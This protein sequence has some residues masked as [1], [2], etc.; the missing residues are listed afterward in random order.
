MIKDN[1]LYE[2]VTCFRTAIDN[3]RDAGMFEKD[4]VFYKFPKACCG[5]TCVLLAEYLRTKG[6]ET[7]YVCV[8]EEDQTHAWL[9]LKDDRVIPPTPYKTELPNDIR[10]SLSLY[11]GAQLGSLII[12]SNYTEFDIEEGLIIDITSDQFGEPPLYIDYIWDF[13]RRFTFVA[14]HDYNGLGSVRLNKIY[15]VILNFME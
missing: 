13:H 2:Y 8:A 11:D 3:A 12:N 4:I 1:V 10:M 15:N 7:I 6:I 5:D 9:I 14:A